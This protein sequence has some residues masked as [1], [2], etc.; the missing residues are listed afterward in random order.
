LNKAI[1]RKHLV[2]LHDGDEADVQFSSELAYRRQPLAACDPAGSD[3]CGDTR[4]E[5]P[6][7]RGI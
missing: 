5:L 7:Q 1:R 3:Q 2:R 4:V 6:V